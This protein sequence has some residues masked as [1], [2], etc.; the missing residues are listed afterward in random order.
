MRSLVFMSVYLQTAQENS[1]L[2]ASS[3]SSI[4]YGNI[5]CFPSCKCDPFALR[6]ALGV[7][8]TTVCLR[9]GA[10]FLS[11]QNKLSHLP[12]K[13][14]HI[15]HLNTFYLLSFLSDGYEMVPQTTGVFLK[16]IFHKY[17]LQKHDTLKHC[18]KAQHQNTRHLISDMNVFHLTLLF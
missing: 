10:M 13:K 5:N 8:V 1:Y 15:I 12:F 14:W 6:P 4:I 11:I 9:H 17:F 18:C 3:S 16:S 7:S 2:A